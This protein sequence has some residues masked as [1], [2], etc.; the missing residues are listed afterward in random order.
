M[1]KKEIYP[2]TTR[3]K[4]KNEVT[5]TEK[6]DGSNLGLFLKG[7]NL[8]ICTRST[9][10]NLN[11][12]DN[13]QVKD[14]IKTYKGLY[15]W[16]KTHG[17]DLKNRLYP[18]SG[19]FGEWMGSGRLSYPNSIRGHY[20]YMFAKARITEDYSAEKIIY[21]HDL[22]KYPFLDETIPDYINM[23]PIVLKAKQVP[24]LEELNQLYDSYSKEVGR[25]VEGFVINFYDNIRKYVRMKG[26]KLEDH[27]E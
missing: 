16:L 3:V 2:K 23:V 11:E 10:F 21:D 22:L 14:D 12:L 27:H 1:I 25:N 19:V 20:F 17:E 26:G 4:V 7:D 18:E 5:I 8:I 9:I 24:S 15:M 13:Q 6:L